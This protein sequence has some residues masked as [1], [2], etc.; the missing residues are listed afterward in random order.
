MISVIQKKNRKFKEIN[1]YQNHDVSNYFLLPFRFQKINSKTEILVNE[2][3]D[4]L[5]VPVG[6]AEQI[7]LKKLDK[8]KDEDLYLDLISNFFISEEVIPPLLNILEARYR[9][10]KSFLDHFT[11]LHIFVISLRCE[12]TCHYCQVSRVTE[13][14]DEFDMSLY[15]ID[16]GIKIMMHSPNPHITMEF[17]GGEALLAFNNIKYAVL[18]AKEEALLYEKHMTFVICTNLA[19]LTDDMLPFIKEHNIMISSSLDGPAFIHNQNRHRPQRNS[20]E[21]TIEGLNKC[22]AILGEDNISALLTTTN[23]SLDYPTEIVEEYVKQ[24]FSNI[25]LRPI[26]PY[27]FATYNEKKNKYQTEKFLTF[28]KSAFEKIIDYNKKGYYIR[29][30][31]ATVI[32]KKILTSFPVGYVDLQSPAGMINNVIVFNYDGKIYASDEARMLAEMNDFTF[33]LGILGQSTYN[34]IFYGKKAMEIAENWT[35]ES[36]AGCSECAF[37]SYCG[38]DPVLNHATQGNMYGYRPTNV[39]CQKNMEIIRYL[40]DLM[41]DKSIEKIFR[42]WIT[43]HSE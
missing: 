43:G 18:K 14:K 41:E 40:F 33:Q 26:S 16:E 7:I 17:Q 6:T 10:K 25:F 3:G 36:L 15:H 4:F 28:Y 8:I 23:L 11:A 13:N 9:T 42:S 39:F 20:Y 29:E 1:Y 38:A 34:E 19:P 12:H 31:Y 37:Q 35:N 30:D 2:V 22:R 21:V 27:G 32:L 5:L 24:G